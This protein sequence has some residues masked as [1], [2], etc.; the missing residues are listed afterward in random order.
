MPRQYSLRRTRPAAAAHFAARRE[1]SAAERNLARTPRRAAQHRTVREKRVADQ[2]C[3]ERGHDRAASGARAVAGGHAVCR[4]ADHRSGYASGARWRTSRRLARMAGQRRSESAVRTARAGI[5]AGGGVG[6][7]RPHRFAD[8]FAAGRALFERDEHP[9]D[10]ARRLAGPRRFRGRRSAG[11]A[12]PRTPSGRRTQPVAVAAARPGAGCGDDRQLRDRLVRLCAVAD[13]AGDG[14]RR[15]G[16]RGRTAFQCAELRGQL[17]VDAGAARTRLSAH[18][19]REHDDGE[20]S[21][22]LRPECVPDRSLSRSVAIDLSRQ[23]RCRRAPRELGRIVHDHR[24]HRLLRGV[25][26]HRV[27]HRSTACSPSAI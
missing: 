23:P 12:R 20:G 26:V 9:P 13:S 11:Q 25:R 4:Q 8:R 3:A 5:R 16:V 21:E 7:P 17:S 1:G 6:H 19:R 2:P 14:R 24:H 15:S 18:G 10:A 22:K 27:A